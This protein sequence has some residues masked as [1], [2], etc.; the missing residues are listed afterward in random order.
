MTFVASHVSQTRFTAPD[1]WCLEK[2][3]ISNVLEFDMVAI[4]REKVPTVNLFRHPRSRKFHIFTEMT[5]FP[6]FRKLDFFGVSQ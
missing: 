5:I 3:E 1:T 4:F 2:R 6:F